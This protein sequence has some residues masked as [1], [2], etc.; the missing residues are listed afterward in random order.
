MVA[1]V[2]SQNGNYIPNHKDGEKKLKF[3][4]SFS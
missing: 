3:Q 1:V 2:L 4:D